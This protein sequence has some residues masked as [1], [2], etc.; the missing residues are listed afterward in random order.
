MI[1]TLS[2]E[3]IKNILSANANKAKITAKL[4][5]YMQIIVAVS[6]DFQNITKNNYYSYKL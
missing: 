5:S 4:T 6:R 2:S 3:K 1:G